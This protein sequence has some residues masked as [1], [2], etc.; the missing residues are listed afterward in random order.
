MTKGGGHDGGHGSGF[1]TRRNVLLAIAGAIAAAA[2][3]PEQHAGSPS[4]PQAKPSPRGVFPIPASTDPSTTPA[5]SGAI[6]VEIDEPGPPEV[7]F[8]GDPAEGAF[9]LTF[10][11]GTCSTCAGEIVA[12][13]AASGMHATFSPN[14]YMGP[15]VWDAQAESIAA[16]AA[17]GQVSICNHTWDH[18]DL[19][20]LSTAQ[21]EAELLR[22]EEWIQQRFGVSSRPFYRPPYGAHDPRVDD[23]AGGIGFTKVIMWNGTF[24]DSIVHPPAFILHQLQEYLKPGTIML[25]HANHP[26]T[27]SMIDE[28]IAQVRQS[29]LR[30][31]TLV[32][33]LGLGP[34]PNL[35]RPDVPNLIINHPRSIGRAR[36]DI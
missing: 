18:K 29:G 2:L 36:T 7:I 22:N 28:I 21:V 19:T 20:T 9:A 3:G 4:L 27:A 32:E 17:T 26:A 23:I 11:D 12:G 16:M 35:A 24:G 33:M 10:D 5:P 25:G 13:I 8:G 31:V 34:N 14:G 1:P 15:H 30:P 6:P